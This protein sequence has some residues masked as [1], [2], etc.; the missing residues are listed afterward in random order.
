MDAEL[1]DLRQ[2]TFA[3]ARYV[4]AL[5]DQLRSAARPVMMFVP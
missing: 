5:V 4:L 1:D 3:A 2:A